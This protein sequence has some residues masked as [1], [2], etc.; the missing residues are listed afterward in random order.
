LLW[1]KIDTAGFFHLQVSTSTW[2][3][4]VATPNG[5]QTIDSLNTAGSNG[6]NI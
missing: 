1:N 2:G 3:T 4:F 5:T 6:L